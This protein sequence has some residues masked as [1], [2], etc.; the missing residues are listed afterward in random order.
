MQT[1]DCRKSQ[2]SNCDITDVRKMLGITEGGQRALI[3]IAQ[4]AGGDYDITGAQRVGET[5]AVNAVRCLLKGCEVC[6]SLVMGPFVQCSQW[7]PVFLW[8]LNNEHLRCTPW[9]GHEFSS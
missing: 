7:C 2:L 4:L 1:D 6:V 5:L 3:A 8:T 9:Y